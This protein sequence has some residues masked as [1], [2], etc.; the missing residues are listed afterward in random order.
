[1]SRLKIVRYPLDP[2]LNLTRLRR[3]P[4]AGA[5]DLWRLVA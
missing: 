2:D 4:A 3:D 5:S 1:M